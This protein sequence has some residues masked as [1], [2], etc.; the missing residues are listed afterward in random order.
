MLVKWN[1]PSEMHFLYITMPNRTNRQAILI[2]LFLNCVTLI[3]PSRGRWDHHE[4]HDM[5]G[6]FKW[7]ILP[8][9]EI[10]ARELL[11]VCL[12]SLSIYVHVFDNNRFE[13][14]EDLK[15]RFSFST[16]AN[17]ISSDLPFARDSAEMY[18]LVS[19]DRAPCL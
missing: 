5:L 13:L 19:W 10:K 18:Y 3:M 2:L 11:C 12:D 6:N 7:I 15:L 4:S 14:L 8:K 1:D 17:S 9:H 16:I